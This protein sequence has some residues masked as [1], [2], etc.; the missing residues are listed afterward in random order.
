[1]VS[2]DADIL[3]S[4]IHQEGHIQQNVRAGNVPENVFFVV[5]IVQKSNT[6]APFK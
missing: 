6:K 5:R 2:F 3:W 4:N 1:M